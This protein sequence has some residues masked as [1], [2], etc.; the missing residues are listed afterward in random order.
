MEMGCP[1]E[2]DTQMKAAKRTNFINK[3]PSR[4]GGAVYVCV[5]DIHHCLSINVVIVDM[6]INKHTFFFQCLV[7]ET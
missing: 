1:T 5:C 6:N 7:I 2:E 3:M 4:A